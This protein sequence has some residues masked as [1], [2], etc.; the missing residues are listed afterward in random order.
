MDRA[1]V[2]K[3]V[4][5]FVSSAF[6]ILCL[7]LAALW[8]QSFWFEDFAARSRIEVCSNDGT[9]MFVSR[10]S[11]SHPAWI[12]RSVP[13]NNRFGNPHPFQYWQGKDFNGQDFTLITLPHWFLVVLTAAFVSIPWLPFS[14]RFGL[15]SLF[16]ITTVL[17]VLLGIVAWALR[18]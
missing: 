5:I 7:L 16:A 9:V 18:W 13:L 1:R 3:W 8:A 17:A 6:G 4:R 2:F 12:V 15:K 10:S 14:K 11:F